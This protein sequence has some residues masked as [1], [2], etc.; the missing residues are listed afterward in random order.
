[1]AI[2]SVGKAL[3]G[4]FP[5]KLMEKISEEHGGIDNIKGERQE[6]IMVVMVVFA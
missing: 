1:M 3:Q 6:E 5:T 4:S 2:S